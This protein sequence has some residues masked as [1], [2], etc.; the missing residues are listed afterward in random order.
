MRS[1]Q[2]AGARNV[3]MTLWP[4]DDALAADFMLDFYRTWLEDNAYDE[5]AE[6]LR[7]TQLAWI[8][9]GDARKSDPYFWAPYVVV[10]RR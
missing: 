9:S 4:L 1:F 6:A 8:R 3:L 2:L 7:A 5:P 10:E